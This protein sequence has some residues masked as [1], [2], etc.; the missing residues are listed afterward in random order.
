M[1]QI[2]ALYGVGPTQY[3]VA[4]GQPLTNVGRVDAAPFV[5]DDWRVLPSMTLSLG[6][7]YEIQNNIGN[8]NA[9]APRVGLAW[10]LGGG[11]GRNRSPKT[12]IRAGF[13]LFYDSVDMALTLAAE[14]QNPNV[15]PT[16]LVQ[17]PNANTNLDAYPKALTPGQ[18]AG[19]QQSQNPLLIY[20][21]IQAPQLIQSAIG[22]D[23]QLPKNITLSVNVTDTR[24]VHELRE[25]NLN[26]P[27]PVTGAHPYAALYGNGIVD[28]YESSGLFKQLQISANTQ[29]RI[30]NRVNM[31]GYYVWGQAHSNT[32]GANTFPANNYNLAGEWSRAGFDRRQQVQIGGSIQAPLRITFSPNINFT[33]APPLNIILGRDLNGDG[34]L[35]DRPAFASL[36]M[37]GQPGILATPWGVFNTNPQPGDQIIPRNYA[38]AYG[39]FR[40]NMRVG[41]S[42]GFGERVTRPPNGRGQDQGGGGRGFGGG[43]RGPGGGGRGPG[44]GG[45]GRG[46]GFA[47]GGRGGRGGGGAAGSNNRY[48]VN[49]SAEIQNVLNTVNTPAP[50]TNLSSPFLGQS[51]AGGGNNAL[52][53]RR[54][55]FSLRFQF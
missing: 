31:F 35:N 40:F 28:M 49:L 50:V 36:S 12:V 42:W 19:F 5:Q 4:A 13:G 47:G 32:D 22:L 24:G 33:T 38:Q 55:S 37:I 18:L 25:R 52:A 15:Q 16:Y 51:L 3:S 11:Q 45:G 21:G 2:R 23:R 48:T 7:R 34:I 46:G 1:P 6:M 14:R 43:G 44:G 29:M 30:N 39:Q 26:A 10:G 54:V 17:F 27:D 53:N 9:F 20:S 41:R 8:K